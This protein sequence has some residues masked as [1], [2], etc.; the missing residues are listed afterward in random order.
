MTIISYV[1]VVSIYLSS[2]Y[3]S[4]P[5]EPSLNCSKEEGLL[6]KLNLASKTL[7]FPGTNLL[8]Q[9]YFHHTSTVPLS[10]SRSSSLMAGPPFAASM[11]S[12]APSPAAAIRAGPPIQP[13]R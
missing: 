10:P 3:L 4:L 7:K 2:V 9:Q 8:P 6:L 5:D 1:W 13:G 12:S 11:E